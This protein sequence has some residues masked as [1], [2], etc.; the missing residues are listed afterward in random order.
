[1]DLV[2]VIHYIQIF[3]III[4][5][6]LA[7]IYSIPVF[8]LH[9]FQNF[10]NIFTTNLCLATIC[11]NIYWLIYYLLLKFYPEYLFIDSICFILIY[12]E[13]M[14]TFQVPLAYIVISINR[15]CSIVYQT[16]L[17][18]KRKLWVIICITIQWI[19]GL[20]FSIPRIPFTQTVSFNLNLSVF[21]LFN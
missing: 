13:M 3:I 19:I 9:R 21:I 15:L 1:M 8:F 6:I 18:F 11:C 14:C 4:T 12:F 7:F 2:D 17:F 20:I 5:I 16:N 10:N